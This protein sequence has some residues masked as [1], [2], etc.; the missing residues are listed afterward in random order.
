MFVSLEGII[1][2]GSLGCESGI[3]GEKRGEK[4]PSGYGLESL[5]KNPWLPFQGGPGAFEGVGNEE[6][7]H[8]PRILVSEQFS[9]W[10]VSFWFLLITGIAVGLAKTTA[11]NVEARGW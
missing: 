5:K 2:Q 10:V 7:P 8:H 1:L 3:L 11:H 6:L 9:G 4:T